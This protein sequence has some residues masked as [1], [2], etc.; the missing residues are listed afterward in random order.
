MRSY[1]PRPAHSRHFVFAKAIKNHTPQFVASQSGAVAVDFVAL[2]VA[3]ATLAFAAVAYA[4][5]TISGVV[6]GFLEDIGQTGR[7]NGFHS[8]EAMTTGDWQDFD[9]LVHDVEWASFARHTLWSSLSD[10]MLMLFHLQNVDRASGDGAYNERA[11]SVDIAVV[12]ESMLIERGFGLPSGTPRAVEL[13]AI[14][15]GRSC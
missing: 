12:T 14:L 3:L 2:S 6:S 13:C 15:R 7:T 5:T 10:E 9:Y 8:A 11:E 4:S 1:F